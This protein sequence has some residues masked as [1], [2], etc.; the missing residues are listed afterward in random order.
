MKAERGDW[1]TTVSYPL[2]TQSAKVQKPKSDVEDRWPLLQS[3]AE[4]GIKTWETPLN[5]A[6]SAE[7]LH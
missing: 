3:K 7:L 4:V 1:L 6:V 2:N 5:L